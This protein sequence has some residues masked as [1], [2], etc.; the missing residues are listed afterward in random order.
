M[1]NKLKCRR[2]YDNPFKSYDNVKKPKIKNYKSL[3]DE[4]IYVINILI[5]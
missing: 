4:H 1:K 5:K 2:R 3:K